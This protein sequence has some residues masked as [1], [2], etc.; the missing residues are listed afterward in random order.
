MVT[1]KD[2]IELLKG[3]DINEYFNT[4]QLLIEIHPDARA[5]HKTF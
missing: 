2:R 4:P 1:H 3:F 5:V